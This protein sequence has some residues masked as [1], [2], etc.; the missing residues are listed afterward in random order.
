MPNFS[1]L[2]QELLVVRCLS[3]IHLTV[4]YKICDEEDKI[5]YQKLKLLSN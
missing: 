4:F 1:V 2:R 5:E 3:F